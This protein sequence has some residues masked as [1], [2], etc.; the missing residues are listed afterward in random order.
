MVLKY[1]SRK[2]KR[3]ISDGE[4]QEH[5]TYCYELGLLV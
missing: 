2:D 4:W 3:V 5:V 1:I